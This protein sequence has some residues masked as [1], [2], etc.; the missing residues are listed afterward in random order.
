MTPNDPVPHLRP[1]GWLT[2]LALFGSAPPPDNT[3]ALLERLGCPQDGLEVV[4]VAGTNGKGSTAKLLADS[5]RAGGHR[6]G[7][8]V[9]PHLQDVTERIVTDGVN[10]AAADLD[11]TLETIRPA[12]VELGSTFFEVLTCAA[13]LTFARAGVSWAV[14]EVGMGGRLD[15]TNALE[16]RMSLITKI[17]LDHQAVLGDDLESIAREKAGVMRPGRLTLTS[18]DGPALK[19][20]RIEG[21]RV[22]AELGVLGDVFAERVISSTWAGLALE[23]WFDA[24]WL[25]AQR[26]GGA[27]TRTLSGRPEPVDEGLSLRPP[28]SLSTRLTGLHQAGNVALAATAALCLGVEPDAVREAVAKVAWPGRLE[29]IRYADRWVVL[30]GAHNP[31]GAASLAEALSQLGGGIDTLLLAVGRDKDAGAM[32][33]PLIVSAGYVVTTAVDA[34]GR[35]LEAGRLAEVVREERAALAPLLGTKAALGGV[36]G[37]GVSSTVESVS[38]PRAALERALEATPLGGTL[39][40]AGSLHLVGELRAVVLGEG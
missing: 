6:V 16:P 10:V 5:L 28:L 3:R 20:L 4:L 19:A 35:F 24:P 1:G 32:A 7:L 13:L 27:G 23:L 40:V 36:R 17:A 2:T 22:G 25:A 37:G 18:A 14:M 33:R 21:A 15:P 34:S 11:A 12:A 29:R 30:D 8:F 39:V 26:G 9:S 31:H 38:D